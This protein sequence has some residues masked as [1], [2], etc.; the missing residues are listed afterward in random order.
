[1]AFLAIRNRPLEPANK[2]RAYIWVGGETS[3]SGIGPPTRGLTPGLRA[4][5]AAFGRGRT[6]PAGRSMGSDSERRYSA[7]MSFRA[8]RGISRRSRNRDNSAQWLPSEVRCR[9]RTRRSLA[10]KRSPGRRYPPGALSTVFEHG[11]PNPCVKHGRTSD[12]LAGFGIGSRI[13][14]IK[15]GP[16]C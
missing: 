4:Y 13:P 8:C 12:E 5:W 1:M 6:S 10:A 16:T 14:C 11:S 7:T 15:H 2:W 9:R 3:R